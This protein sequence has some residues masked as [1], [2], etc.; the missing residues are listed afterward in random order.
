MCS[1]VKNKRGDKK[2]RYTNKIHKRQSLKNLSRMFAG[3]SVNML[4]GQRNHSLIDYENQPYMVDAPH[5]I[6]SI[7]RFVI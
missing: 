7:F 6:P 1:S 4:S 2:K 3:G 5:L